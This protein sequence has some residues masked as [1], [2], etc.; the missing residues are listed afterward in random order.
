MFSKDKIN[1]L[2]FDI[3]SR[4]ISFFYKNKEKFG[5]V[6]GFVLTV[7]YIVLS[8]IIF[9]IYFI[10]T[11]K[12]VEVTASDST[13]YPTDIP[14]IDINNHLFYI[15]F[16]LED[17]V[18]LTR[19]INE[20]IY[21]PEVIFVEKIKVN[22]E[23]I[24][25]SETVLEIE[26]CSNIKFGEE[27]QVLL[28]RHQ[29]NNS[30]CIKELNLKLEGG[31]SH[32]KMSYI[33]INIYPCV[34]NTQN[35]N[36]CQSQ[37]IIDK[38]LTSAYFS[39]LAKDIGLNPMNF[40]VPI[41]PLL[42]YLYT[43]IDKSILKEYIIYFGITEINTDTGLFFNAIK[44]ETYLKYVKDLHSIFFIEN[45]QNYAGKEIFSAQIRLEETINFHKR[46]FTKMS[47]VLSITGGYMQIISTVFALIALLTK[48]FSLEQNLLNSIFN[49][50][51]KQRK[52][53]LCIE[54]KKRLDYNPNLEKKKDN[55]NNNNTFILYD[56]KKSII[57]KKSR[58][59][60]IL[61]FKHK[62]DSTMRR[63]VT[64]QPNMT[65]KK[66]IKSQSGSVS[67]SSQ[68]FSQLSKNKPKNNEDFDPNIN[69]SKI[70]MIYKEDNLAMNDMFKMQKPK[71]KK[72]NYNI[73]N[74]LK[75][76]DQGRRSTVNFTIFDYYCLKKLNNK[77]A[78]IEL[79]NFGI[80]FFK[81][82]MDII[83]FFNILILTQIMLTQQ[84]E[85]KQ[86]Y[87]TRTIEL[88]MD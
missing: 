70:N 59:D 27:Y 3:Y 51:I 10:R 66:S 62:K 58:R 74:D 76:L 11:L 14:S 24:T 63:S 30:Y 65:G 45:K 16:G 5:S 4:R 1:Y 86:N 35:S 53:I 25:K 9:L 56:P 32:I 6:F 87:L 18:K 46:T 23:F 81:S 13:V 82:Q 15:A 85:K 75:E 60:S 84:T 83:N 17:P 54:Y 72:S 22:G 88:S 38:Y 44:K 61:I 73:L 68:L 31:P 37:E 33:K 49:F 2:D 71:K 21:Y 80:N 78:E 12:R 20:T 55:N 79:F 36:H 67:G 48:K 40:K 64:L 7:L 26:K 69:R 19:I 43:P 8:I 28:E 29:I 50:N 39:I 42:Q 41:I 34:N 47:Q 77:K 57:S 52:I